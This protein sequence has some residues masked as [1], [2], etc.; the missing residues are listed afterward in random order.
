MNHLTTYL[1]IASLAMAVFAA[2]IVMFIKNRISETLRTFELQ[3]QDGSK[4]TFT[5]GEDEDFSEVVALQLI[6][7]NAK[8]RSDGPA[9][10]KAT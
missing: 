1:I 7:M 5:V 10:S 4:E 8:Q 3:D 6:K 9:P 2:L